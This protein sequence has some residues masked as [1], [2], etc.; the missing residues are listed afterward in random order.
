MLLIQLNQYYHHFQNLIN[1]NVKIQLYNEIN[2][3]LPYTG[4]IT[5]SKVDFSLC[6][7]TNENLKKSGTIVLI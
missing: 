2:K 4:K 5:N 6:D 7:L 3:H 1:F